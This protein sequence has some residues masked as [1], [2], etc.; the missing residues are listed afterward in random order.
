M[1][2]THTVAAVVPAHN[3]APFVGTV[4][5]EMPSFVDRVYVVDDASSDGTHEAVLAAAP[6]AENHDSAFED[7]DLL[8]S[9][10]LSDRVATVTRRGRVVLLRHAE[11]RGP[12]GAVATGYLAALSGGAELVATV[13]GDGQMNPEQLP[14][15]LDPLVDGEADFATGTRLL[16]GGHAREMP[17]LRLFGNY[18]LTLLCRLSSGYWTLT[19]PVNGYTTITRD[20]LV[21]IDPA[22]THEGYGYGTQLL[23]RLHADDRRVVDV[24]HASRYGD[25]ESGIDYRRYATRVSLLLLRTFLWRLSRERLG[26]RERTADQRGSEPGWKP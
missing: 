20:A 19:D 1:Y 17:A 2:R 16:N 5:A 23:A 12:G 25:E 14:R 10:A 6:P 9:T 11:N 21:A 26:L 4:L 22:S 7:A 8:A 18:V 3:E 24:P 15:F 13:D